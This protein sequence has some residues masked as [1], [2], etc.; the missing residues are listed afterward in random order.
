[1]MKKKKKK[2]KSKH[3]LEKKKKLNWRTKKDRIAF[4]N[5]NVSN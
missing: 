5:Y 3:I 1:M 2:T 4:K